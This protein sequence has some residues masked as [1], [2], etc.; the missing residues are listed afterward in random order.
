[1]SEAERE[2]SIRRDW[3][4]DLMSSKPEPTRRQ[5]LGFAVDVIGNFATGYGTGLA[6]MQALG[7]TVYKDDPFLDFKRKYAIEG[8]TS[9]VGGIIFTEKL[10]RYLAPEGNA[11]TQDRFKFG[12]WEG[13]VTGSFFRG[14]L[15]RVINIDRS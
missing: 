12:Q 6:G 7:A 2:P 4:K 13:F 9:A 11:A 5:F 1:M 10:A 14:A 8:G 3:E 15:L